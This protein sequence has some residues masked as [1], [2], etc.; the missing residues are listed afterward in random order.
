MITVKLQIEIEASTEADVAGEPVF[1]QYAK[2]IRDFLE[3]CDIAGFNVIDFDL[4]FLEVEFQW[5]GVDFSRQDRQLVDS[6]II[7]HMKEPCDLK[8]AYLK[9]CDMETDP[10]NAA[11]A[12]EYQEKIYYFCSTACHDKFNAEPEKYIEKET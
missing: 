7:F 2:S 11:V 5:T 6:M 10:N 4:P 8:A 9:Y 12:K 1:R 3:D